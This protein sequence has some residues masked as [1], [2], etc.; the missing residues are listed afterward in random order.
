MRAGDKF[1]KFGGGTKNLGDWFTDK[2]IP[3]RLRGS[4]PLL[5]DGN[6]ILIVFGVEISEKV[7]VDKD[8]KDD[9]CAIAADYGKI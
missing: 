1:T 5:A 4:I 6:D 9:M 8:T 3:V 7:K 2:K